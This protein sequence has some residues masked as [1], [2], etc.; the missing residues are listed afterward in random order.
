MATKSMETNEEQAQE[1]NFNYQIPAGQGKWKIYIT[2]LN[3]KLQ[4]HHVLR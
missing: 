3:L 2:F 4:S 1:Q